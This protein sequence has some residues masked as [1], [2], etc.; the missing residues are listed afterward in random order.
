MGTVSDEK[1]G[2]GIKTE[3]VPQQT[4]LNISYVGQ[5]HSKMGIGVR[6]FQR[7]TERY[8]TIEERKRTTQ[9]KAT[10]LNWTEGT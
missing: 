3:K 1:S 10:H 8:Q 6:K 7:D 5:V 4:N 2:R 9:Y